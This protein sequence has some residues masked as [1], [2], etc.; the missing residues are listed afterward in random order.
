MGCWKGREPRTGGR[1]RTPDRSLGLG[2]PVR[3]LG[4]G[5]KPRNA[6]EPSC[7]CFP[8]PAPSRY[9]G[10]RPWTPRPGGEARP[11]GAAANR[12]HGKGQNP[13]PEAGAKPR[14]TVEPHTDAAAR[15]RGPEPKAEASTPARGLVQSPGCG[16]WGRA[17]VPGS[18]AKP[19]LR[20]LGRSP[21]TR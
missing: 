12:R 20:D 1:G 13:V 7:R 17:P 21:A 4:A 15:G 5:A 11:H 19:Q 16:G 3:G 10:L 6:A 8:L 9:Q 18:G 2:T 14:H